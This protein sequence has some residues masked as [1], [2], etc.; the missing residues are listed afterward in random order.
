MPTEEQIA[1]GTVL[2]GAAE[3]AQRLGFKG[4]RGLERCRGLMDAGTIPAWRDGKQYRAHWPTVVST[5]A[6][7]GGVIMK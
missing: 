1:A 3:L 4:K 5:L 6:A 7:K 2:L